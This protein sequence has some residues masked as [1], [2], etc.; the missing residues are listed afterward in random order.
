[1]L[2]IT[3]RQ[4]AFFALALSLLVGATSRMEGDDIIAMSAFISNNGGSGNGPNAGVL[5]L[6]GGV[7]TATVR[8]NAK[9]VCGKVTNEGN[10]VRCV[11]ATTTLT[12]T[13]T[14]TDQV[15]YVCL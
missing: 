7:Q 15:A 1:M 13:G 12:A 6:S 4:L 11:V 5:T 14:G 3:Y 2:T 10:P 8:T 9:C